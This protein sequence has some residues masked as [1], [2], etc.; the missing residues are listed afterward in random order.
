ML[1]NSMR[2]ATSGGPMIIR[3]VDGKFITDS[4]PIHLDE[5]L[6]IYV[7]GLGATTPAVAAGEAAPSNP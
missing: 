2:Q 4:T 7:T 3:T 6:I 5:K 1:T